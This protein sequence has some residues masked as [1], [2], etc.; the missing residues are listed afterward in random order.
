MRRV[1]FMMSVSVDGF[2]ERPDGDI[3]W[4][5]VDDEIHRHFNELVAPMG[6]YLTGRRT[7]ELMAEVWPTADRD[8]A[9]TPA[10]VEY[11]HIWRDKPKYVFSRTLDHADWSTRI[12]HDVVPAEINAL[13][14]EPGGDM[15]VGG[16]DL[17]ASFRQLDLIDEYRVYVHP[18][19][20]GRGNPM[21]P[22]L[23]VAHALRLVETRSFGNG[24]VLL[25]YERTRDE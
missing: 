19:L 22:P 23:D 14:A 18:V 20:I 10:M 21:F 2:M 15:V 25:R 12:L 16:A 1:V 11:A 6:A 8:F 9:D 5:L 13:K 17:A 4:N 3:S 24:V 7:H